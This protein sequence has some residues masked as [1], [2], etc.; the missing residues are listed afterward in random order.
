MSNIV[1]KILA[2]VV[3]YNKDLSESETLI[4]LG[5]D[6]D[7]QNTLLD[8][9]IYDNS[10]SK[11]RSYLSKGFNVVEHFYDGKNVGVSAAYNEG[12][13]FAKSKSKEWVLLLDQDTSFEIG[14]LKEYL[15]NIKHNPDINLFSPIIKLE[16]GVVFSPFRKFF[17]RGVALK[18]VNSTKYSLKKY[19]PVN[20]GMLVKVSSF[21]EA[22]GYN[23]KIKLDF[24]DIEFINRFNKFNKEFKVINSFCIQDFSNAEM[25]VRNLNVRFS[26]FCNGVKNCYR[27]NFY[28]DFQYFIVVLIRMSILIMR[29]KKMIFVKTFY[30][31]Y[32]GRE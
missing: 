26:F 32:I 2:I 11:Q 1:D 18:N 31:S 17:K 7:S 3:V 28:E 22:N 13:K 8:L 12:V 30:K 16:S 4:S 27:K 10:N 29:T 6:I 21:I 23:E 25:D 24:S 5:R 9:F 14:A 15:D 20:S 19:S